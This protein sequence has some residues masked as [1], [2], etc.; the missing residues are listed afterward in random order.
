M[1]DK[2]NVLDIFFKRMRINGLMTHMMVIDT[3]TL[4]IK[5]TH[6]SS[7]IKHLAKYAI[8]NITMVKLND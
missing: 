3:S 5:K 4:L 8:A 6:P 7:L 1:I 2:T